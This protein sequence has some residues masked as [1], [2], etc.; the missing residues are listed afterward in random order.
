MVSQKSETK[1][2]PFSW[3]LRRQKMQK[4][5]RRELWLSDEEMKLID[6]KRGSMSRPNFIRQAA[7]GTIPKQI[8]AINIE[9]RMELAK[10]GGNLNQ[11]A[12]AA[13]SGLD[14][15]ISEIQ[16]EISKLRLSLI[17]VKFCEQ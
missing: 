17:G 2:P 3:I 10:I 16:K 7:I 11:I 1:N 14:I 4:R 8:P 15:E 13:N 12:R 5:K 6:E 9:A